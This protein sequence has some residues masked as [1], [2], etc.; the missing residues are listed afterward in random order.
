MQFAAPFE[1][2]GLQVKKEWIDY[3]GHMNM[4]FYNVMFDEGVDQA[5]E[6][7]GL[8][9]DYVKAQNAS[10]FTLEA[11]INYVREVHLDMPLRVTLQILD[12]DSK[13]VHFFMEMY[14]EK[15][16]W[17]A[18]TSE[19]LCMHVDMAAKRSSPFP[20]D[21]LAKITAMYNAHKELPRAPQIGSVI[22]IKHK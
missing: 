6:L 7:V 4:A 19:Q 21:V 17:L 11:H 5:F 10:Y 13:R 16:G 14:H 20:E 22:G 8:G 3:N 2:R 9:P 12:F 15:E 18:A 1:V